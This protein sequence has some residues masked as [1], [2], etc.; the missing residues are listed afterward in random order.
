LK[1]QV[2]NLSKLII[3]ERVLGYVQIV[4]GCALGGLAYPM[5]L[6]PNSIAPG[7]LTGVATILNKLFGLPVG[8][9]SMVLNL[10][11]FIIGFHAM[12]R[13]FVWRSLI[14]T[15]LFSVAIDVI[16]VPPLTNDVLLG[17]VYGGVLLGIGVGIIFRGE[18]TTG[19]SDMIAR[20]IHRRF[21]FISIGAFLFAIDFLVV[22]A[23][24]FVVGLQHA[25]Y[26]LIC[27]FVTAKA[28]D[29]VLGGFS[30]QKACFVIT[31]RTVAVTSRIME[32]MERGVTLLTARGAYSGRERPV[33]LCV[34]GRQEVPRVKEIVRQEDETAFMFITEAHEVL[35]EGFAKFSA[36]K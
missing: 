30:T 22:T 14:A 3:R 15:V 34:L 12:G 27:I 9:T 28:V 23:A 25:L 2:D 36:D 16:H 26:A 13:V 4:V 24:G 18:A 17:S 6:L 7:G 31:E 35:G 20:M 1:R 19:G 29:V 33:I 21:P 5:F 32:E 8:L 11:L 10:P